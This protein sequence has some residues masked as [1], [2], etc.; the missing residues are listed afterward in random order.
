MGLVPANGLYLNQMTQGFVVCSTG[1][2]GQKCAQ[3]LK[4]TPSIGFCALVIAQS[5]CSADNYY[6]CAALINIIQPHPF[7]GGLFKPYPASLHK[8]TTWLA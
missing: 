3:I 6:L 2:R 1:L 4:K 5:R 7:V 8:D